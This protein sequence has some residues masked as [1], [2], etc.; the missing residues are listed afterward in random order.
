M[1]HRSRLSMPLCVLAAMTACGSPSVDGLREVVDATTRG[2]PCAGEGCVDEVEPASGGEGCASEDFT[3][4]EAPV[5]QSPELHVVGI[6]ESRD[7]H[8]FNSH[9]QGEASVHVT[10]PGPVVLGVSSYEPTHWTIT[11]APNTKILS[12]IALG[13][14]AQELTVPLGT[15]VSVHTY[16]Q[17][18]YVAACG[19]AWPS[20]DGGCDTPGTI[21]AMEEKSGLALTSFQGCYTGTSFV[22]GEGAAA[23]PPPSTESDWEPLA[24]AVQDDGTM[25]DGDRYVRFHEGVGLWVGARLCS[26][27]RYKLYL[28]DARDGTY[29]QIGDWA[30]HGQDHCELVDDDFALPNEDD[31]TSGCPSCDLA[32][33]T[34]SD[35][36]KPTGS[37]GYARGVLGEAFEFVD[38]WPEVNLYTVEWHECGVA[39]P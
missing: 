29:L 23:T 13:Y 11:S 37:S 32:P 31:I 7:D 34:F 3:T 9:P 8:S 30:G 36:N 28:S 4:Y 39:I 2:G 1:K 10:R 16:D 26:A 24:F 18:D 19:Y 14:H 25:C 15:E 5:S 35:V 27:T 17:G 21:V 38:V 12:V 20:N 22:V 6:Y 33:F